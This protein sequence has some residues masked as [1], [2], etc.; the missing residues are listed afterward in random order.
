[1]MGQVVVAMICVKSS[2]FLGKK[3][4]NFSW[5]QLLFFLSEI[6]LLLMF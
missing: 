3:N 2:D 1:M 4:L 6:L 5:E